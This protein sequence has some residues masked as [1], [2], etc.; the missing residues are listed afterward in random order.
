MTQP[1]FLSV[2]AGSALVS[3]FSGD[4][5]SADTL[6]VLSPP[7]AALFAP[8]SGLQNASVSTLTQ[9]VTWPNTAVAASLGSAPAGTNSFLVAGGFLVPPKTVGALTYVEAAADWSGVEG[10]WT[11]S[12]PDGN[13]LFGGWFYHM[14]VLYDVDGDGTDDILSARAT[15]PLI[16]ASAG[17]LVWLPRGSLAS[18]PWQEQVLFNGTY[19]PDVFFALRDLDGDGADEIVSAS[20]FSGGAVSVLYLVDGAAT[21]GLWSNAS[22]I[23][24]VVLDTSLGTMFGLSF[25][26]V[27]GD[28]VEDLL[29]TNHVDNIT[30]SGVYAYEIPQG[31]GAWRSPAAWTRHTLATGFPVL[32]PGPGQAAPGAAVLLPQPAQNATARPSIVVSGDGAESFYLLTPFGPADTWAFNTSLLYACNGTTGEPLAGDFNAD[33]ALDLLLPCYDTN[34]IA[35][36]T[37]RP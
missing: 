35:G 28:G 27:N 24:Q 18:V 29:V 30:L 21:P 3:Q 31:P 11:L 16:G 37:L 1:A 26:D 32:I 17:E 2:V 7:L 10:M 20:Y 15:K 33:G 36:F 4:P 23:A 22:A 25:G 8:G 34:H 12:V 6:Q 9:N 5:F 14:A 19:S 13:A